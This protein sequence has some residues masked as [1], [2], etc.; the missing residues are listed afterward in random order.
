MNS[1]RKSFTNALT[2]VG[3]IGAVGGFIADVL[4]PLGNFA[5]WVA[6]LSLIAAL[7]A[8]A[9]FLRLRRRQGPA[10]WDSPVAG[11][12]AIT[13][14]STVIFTV[15]SVIFAAGPERGYLAENIDPIA[16]FQADLLNLQEDV[17]VIRETTEASATQVVAVATQ[18]QDV[19]TG[20]E[21]VSTD[22]EEVSTDV[23]AIATA[24]A[25]GF[26]EIQESFAALQAGEGSIVSNPTTP[27]EWYSNARLYQLRGDTLNALRAYEGYFAFDLEYVDPYLEYSALLRTTEGITRAREAMSELQRAHPD[28]PAPELALTLLLD[29][30]QER[31]EQLGLLAERLPQFGPAF[32]YLGEAYTQALAANATN[33]LLQKQSMAYETL[34]ELEEQQLFSRYFIDKA[35]AEEHLATARNQL[36]SFQTARDVYGNVDIQV[37][38]NYNGVEFFIIMPELATAQKLL[39]GI[40]EPQPTTDAG[41]SPN[42]LVNSHIGPMLLPE[43]EHIFTVQFVDANRASSEVYSKPFRVDPIAVRYAQL[44]MDFSTNTIPATFILGILGATE[45]ETELYTY[46]YSID[47]DSL[48]E[49]TSGAAIAASINA[50][51][52]T[53]GE[54]MLYVQGTAADGTQTEVVQFPF[55]IQ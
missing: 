12:V 21:E 30:P 18:V 16:Q 36:S 17:T 9:A 52:L 19:S 41:R 28:N 22:V 54:H 15:W 6:I 4:A 45:A 55:T 24:Q 43:G 27:Q 35:M 31:A 42:G 50:T 51:G 5:P 2:P 49:T 38:Y 37:Y 44:P 13:L 48:S 20:V 8:I 33:D 25:Q 47:N 23:E 7:M 40:D 34:A 53:P 10:A 46:H 11:G 3:I 39:F 1:I 29:T 32:Y 26:E 14:S